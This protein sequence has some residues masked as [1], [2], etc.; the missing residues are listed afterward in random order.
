MLSV[1]LKLQIKA[2]VCVMDDFLNIGYSY[3]NEKSFLRKNG[4]NFHCIFA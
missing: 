1:E 2:K 4:Y 3:K